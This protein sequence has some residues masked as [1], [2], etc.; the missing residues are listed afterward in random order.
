MKFIITRDLMMQAAKFIQNHKIICD[1]VQFNT[2]LESIIFT[3]FHD[4]KRIV[5]AWVDYT[6]TKGRKAFWIRGKEVK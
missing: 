3:R 4:E 6:N 2:D 5:A 1:E